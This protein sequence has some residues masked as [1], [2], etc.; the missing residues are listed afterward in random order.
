MK[1]FIRQILLILGTLALL[2]SLTSCGRQSDESKSIAE[3]KNDEKFD[4]NS[5]E[6]D[7]QFVVDAVS[8]SYAQLLFAEAAIHRTKDQ[9][10]KGVA[11]VLT[12]E[13]TNNLADLKKYAS[14]RAISIPTEATDAD[15]KKAKS[16]SDEKEFDKAWCEEMRSRHRKTIDNLEN[17]AASTEDD[18]L[19]SW[20]NKALKV[21]RADHDKIMAC[22]ERLK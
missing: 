2:A 9:E 1:H 22:H 15:Q 4:A 6:K 20:A 7:A 13:Q 18:E 19:K 16:I 3:D 21:A 5:G 14:S 17:A 11:T 10:I 8:D 12:K